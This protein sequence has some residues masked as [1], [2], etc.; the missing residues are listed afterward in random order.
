MTETLTAIT[1]HAAG[2]VGVTDVQSGAAPWPQAIVRFRNGYGASIVQ[3][4]HAGGRLEIAVLDSE[5]E[6]TYS[7]RVTSDVIAGLTVTDAVGV[8]CSIAALPYV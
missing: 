2:I 7:T 8:L 1:E 5:G 4:P 6:I 3:L